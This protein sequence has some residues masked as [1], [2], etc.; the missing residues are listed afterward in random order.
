MHFEVFFTS[1]VYYHNSGSYSDK[2]ALDNSAHT[3]NHTDPCGFVKD[4]ITHDR[5]AHDIITH[6]I[7]IIYLFISYFYLAVI[8]ITT[9]GSFMSML[10]LANKHTNTIL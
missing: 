10:I 3:H 6:S 2:I 4:K 7:S 8:T 1:S 9:I 5:I